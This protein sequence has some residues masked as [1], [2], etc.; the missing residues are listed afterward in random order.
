MALDPDQRD[1]AADD[2]KDMGGYPAPITVMSRA[3]ALQ[4]AKDWVAAMGGQF[5]LPEDCGCKEHHY[6]LRVIAHGHLQMT[7]FT[8]DIGVRGEETAFPEIP[9]NFKDDGT[10]TG[11]VIGVPETDN[12]G[13][14]PLVACKGERANRIKVEVKGQWKDITPGSHEP[15]SNPPQP[16]QNPLIVKLNFSQLATAAAETCVTPMGA[17]SGS[18]NRTGPELFTFELVYTDPQ[19][20]QGVTV[21]WP[22]PFPGWSG[23]VRGQIIE[24]SQGAKH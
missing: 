24:V 1:R 17:M 6:A 13:A 23:I 2:L 8:F 3:E 15:T 19:V 10:L 22:A 7:G 11:E 16:P 12:A 14:L 21:E 9:L 18:S 20:N 5:R 4:L